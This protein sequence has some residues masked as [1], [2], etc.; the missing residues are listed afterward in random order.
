MTVRERLL[1]ISELNIEQKLMHM[2][3][4]QLDEYI[5]ALNTF[6]ENLPKLDEELKST[7]AEKDFFSFSGALTDIRDML[8][9]IHA[10]DL[11]EECLKLINGLVSMKPEKIEAHMTYLLSVLTMLSID[12]QMSVYKDETDEGAVEAG[13]NE[14]AD[15]LETWKKS[16]LVVDDNAFFLDSIKFVLKDSGYKL[17]CVNSGM[18]ALR[19][20]Q[21]NSPDLFILDIEMPEMDGYELALKIRAYGKKSPIIFLT[22]NS[23]KDYVVRAIKVGASDFIVKPISRQHV[24]ERIRKFV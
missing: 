5:H 1:A 22:G 11:A 17:T 10:N 2:R 24:L 13:L 7:L 14:G 6:V 12:I 9:L 8:V 4:G 16:I 15:T 21:N 23:S 3:G 20:L 18:A 19:F